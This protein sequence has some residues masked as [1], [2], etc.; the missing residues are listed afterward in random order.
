MAKLQGA[1]NDFCLSHDMEEPTDHLTDCYF[2]VVPSLGHG[3]TKKKIMSVILIFRQLVDRYPTLKTSMFQY[4]R[5]T[6]VMT[7]DALASVHVLITSTL[8]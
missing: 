8:A 3:I 4:H 6:I 1:F 2:C 7:T 5:S